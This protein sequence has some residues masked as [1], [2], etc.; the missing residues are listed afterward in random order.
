[1]KRRRQKTELGSGSRRCVDE[2]LKMEEKYP[3]VG[4]RQGAEQLS[5][6]LERKGELE[7][8]AV[9]KELKEIELRAQ[10]ELEKQKEV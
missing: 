7:R 10:A 6:W 9:D 8:D 3:N 5:T 1:M 2:M 4:W